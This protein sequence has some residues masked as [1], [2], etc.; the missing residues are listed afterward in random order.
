ML[1]LVFTGD[2]M[3][4]RRIGEKLESFGYME[5]AIFSPG[6]LEKLSQADLVVGNLECPLT[7]KGEKLGE[8]SFKAHPDAI[9]TLR[10]FHHFSFANNHIFDCGKK[11]AKE[12][13]EVLTKY[14]KSF[15]GIGNK[16]QIYSTQRIK[17]KEVSF[18]SCAVNYCI[19]NETK[20]SPF[21]LAANNP[22]ISAAIKEIKEKNKESLVVVL[23]HGGNEMI[24]YPEP[25]FRRQCREYIDAGADVVV[26][27]HS[28][29]LGGEE[30][31]KKGII[32]YSLGDF[33]FDGQSYLRRSSGI[34]YLKFDKVFEWELIPTQIEKDLRTSLSSDKD[35][36]IILKGWQ[37]RTKIYKKSNYDY[38]YRQLYLRSLLFF[39]LDRI[40]FLIRNKGIFVTIKFVLSKLSLLSFYF[41][42]VSKRKI[43]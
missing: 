21:I 43:S 36:K 29:V 3:L 31:Y 40:F 35:A 23:I 18:I 20:E 34:L 42:K 4:A 8:T 28:H 5:E 12:T 24:P 9:H 41:K 7:K 37:K 2:I 32:F 1:R 17:G 19:K 25:S 22:K 33:V 13:M 26:S 14:G 38:I 16:E 39:Q 11:G 27:N 10:K 30:K 15:S 6:I